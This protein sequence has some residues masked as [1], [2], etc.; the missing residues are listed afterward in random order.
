MQFRVFYIVNLPA[1]DM[2]G[3]HAHDHWELVYV[4]ESGGHILC[5][6]EKKTYKA[7]DLLIHSPGKKHIC[8]SKA[9]GAHYCLGVAGLELAQLYDAVIPSPPE[10]RRL[11]YAMAEEL[12]SGKPY[13]REIIGAQA[14]EA[15]WK[16]LR[17]VSGNIKQKDDNAATP[18]NALKTILDR[19]WRAKTRL[20]E[21]AGQ[22]LM[23][24]DYL[25]QLFKRNFGLSPVQYLINKRLDYAKDLLK[26]SDQSI[27]AIAFE[28]GFDN[29]HYFSRLFHKAVGISPSQFR[30]NKKEA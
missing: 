15:G 3:N 20:G 30:I 2:S 18:A 23:S 16:L 7:G 24:E 14:M 8:Y 17:L 12:S 19:Q 29:E 22:F 9:A 1:G 28:C 13:Y 10:I 27:K 4:H 6:G 21:L 26:N 5:D 25:R 11:F